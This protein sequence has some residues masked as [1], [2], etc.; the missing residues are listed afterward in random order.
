MFHPL[1]Y[2]CIGPVTKENTFMLGHL[3]FSVIYEILRI[4]VHVKAI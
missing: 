1:I 4:Y 2:I 3:T